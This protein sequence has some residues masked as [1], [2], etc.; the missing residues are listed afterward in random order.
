MRPREACLLECAGAQARLRSCQTTDAL[1][2]RK[3]PVLGM[4]LPDQPNGKSIKYQKWLFIITFSIY[5]NV[6][7]RHLK[8]CSGSYFKVW[9]LSCDEMVTNNRFSVAIPIPLL[10]TS[11]PLYPQLPTFT[12]II[13]FSTNSVN[14]NKPNWKSLKTDLF[15]QTNSGSG[16]LIPEIQAGKATPTMKAGRL[17]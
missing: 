13:A 4:P 9:Y 12:P 1:G 8:K 2:M 11:P 3:S 6:L 7:L 5:I 16:S 14:R 10:S 17:W 15:E